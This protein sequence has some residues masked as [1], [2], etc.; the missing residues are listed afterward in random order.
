MTGTSL[1]P[2]PVP[3]G[4]G[5]I[6]SGYDKNSMFAR[7]S[8]CRENISLQNV[9]FEILLHSSA[10][11]IFPILLPGPELVPHISSAEEIKYKL[12]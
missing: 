11:E 3:V 12:Y 9:V 1:V 5:G 10:T 7:V 2:V 8:F 6:F 4:T